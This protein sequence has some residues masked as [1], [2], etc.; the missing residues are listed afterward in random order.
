MVNNHSQFEE[1][2]QV[3]CGSKNINVGNK[4]HGDPD[5]EELIVGDITGSLNSKMSKLAQK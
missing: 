3:G 2:S 5:N 1:S 4:S